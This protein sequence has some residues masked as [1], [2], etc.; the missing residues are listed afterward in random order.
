MQAKLT[1]RL[2]DRL[3]KRAKAHA[4]A[5]QKS[6]SKMVADYFAA[7]E[8]HPEEEAGLGLTPLVESLVGAFGSG[9]ADREDHRRH[10]E[11]KHR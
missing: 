11:K 2:D 6:V 5:G 8:R 3:I 1:L 7:L 10:L 4:K 9:E